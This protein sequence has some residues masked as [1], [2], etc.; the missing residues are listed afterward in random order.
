VLDCFD[1]VGAGDHFSSCLVFTFLLGL[2]A[3]DE[4]VVVLFDLLTVHLIEFITI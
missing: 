3:R 2:Y 4:V 1:D